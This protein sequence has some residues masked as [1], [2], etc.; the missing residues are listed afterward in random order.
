MAAP[1]PTAACTV[2]TKRTLTVLYQQLQ[3]SPPTHTVLQQ[4]PT[5][6][7]QHSQGTMLAWHGVQAAPRLGFD[8]THHCAPILNGIPSIPRSLRA[9]IFLLLFMGQ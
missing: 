7:Q 6:C 3:G 2:P 8:G 5:H 1:V 4:N 9:E